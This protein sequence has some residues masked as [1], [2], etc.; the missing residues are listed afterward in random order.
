M[1]I[2]NIKSFVNQRGIRM[3]ANQGYIT[4]TE[5]VPIQFPPQHQPFQ[6]G[7]EW[8]MHPRPIAETDQYIGTG[9]LTDKVAIISGGDSGIGRAVAYAFAKEGANIVITYLNEHI[10]ALETKQ[11]IIDIGR[12][13]LLVAGDLGEEETSAFIVNETLKSF[14]RI[15]ILVNNCAEAHPTLNL[16]KI[17][18]EQLLRVYKTNVFSYFYL[19]KA[20]LPHLKEGSSIINTT[21]AVVYVGQSDNLDYSSS[22]GAV[23]TF[24][25]SLALNLANRGIRVNSVS[26]GPIWTPLIPSSFPAEQVMTFGYDTPL[27]RA[28]QP[29]ELAP[30]YVYLASDNSSYVTGQTVHVNGGVMTSS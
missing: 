28:G 30:A 12:S 7:W 5:Q 21:S 11:R 6:P 9:K 27:S 17:T 18:A 15:D 26:P 3:N 23:A 14:G 25:R 4:R 8:I 29:F 24:T 22:K 19:T 2:D 10:D 20:A 1:N 16:T 13:C